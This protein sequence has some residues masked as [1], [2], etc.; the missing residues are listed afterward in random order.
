MSARPCTG[1]C[2]GPT[3]GLIQT[4]ARQTVR[5][6]PLAQTATAHRYEQNYYNYVK[7]TTLS[8]IYS[9]S[10]T[11]HVLALMSLEMVDLAI[12]QEDPARTLE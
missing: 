3:T 12:L 8:S 2:A 4:S 10:A 11:G 7:V 9:I 5:F 1:P 6:G